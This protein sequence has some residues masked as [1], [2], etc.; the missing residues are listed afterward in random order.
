MRAPAEHPFCTIKKAVGTPKANPREVQAWKFVNV[1]ELKKDV[2]LNPEGY[3][4]WFKQILE[5][6]HSALKAS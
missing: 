6:T 2:A 3:T 4:Y 1:E 5:H